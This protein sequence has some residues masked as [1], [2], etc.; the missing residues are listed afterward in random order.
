MRCG[1]F[2][3]FSFYVVLFG[4]EYSESVNQVK[5]KR[6][7]S[8]IIIFCVV[9]VM[10]SFFSLA[11]AE[12]KP[13]DASY[14]YEIASPTIVMVRSENL[15]NKS[16]GSGVC[17][18]N[19]ARIKTGS[20]GKKAGD[21]EITSSWILTNAH[22]V[23]DEKKTSISYGGKSYPAKVEY[24]DRVFDIAILYVEDVV[25]KIAEL[26]D[27]NIKIGSSV[28]AIGSPLGLNNSISDG[29]VSAIRQ[30]NSVPLI[31]TTAPISP[32]NSGG[33]LFDNNGNLVGITSFK[34]KE[35]EYLNFA[36]KSSFLYDLYE[37][38]V[39]AE[40]LLIRDQSRL[41]SS[42]DKYNLI[43]WL[44]IEKNSSGISL[45]KTILQAY[46][47]YA[48]NGND[49]ALDDDSLEKF[50]SDMAAKFRNSVATSDS[51]HNH[52]KLNSSSSSSQ[53]LML[54]CSFDFSTKNKYLSVEVDFKN[55]KANGH[56]ATITDDEIEFKGISINR[57]T[58]KA[59]FQ[60]GGYSSQGKCEPVTEKRF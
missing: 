58:G 25:V 57:Y 41:L 13:A 29:I 46:G 44:A 1:F 34:L 33:G 55:M 19:G 54:D 43:N 7:L 5:I 36:I 10:G 12:K 56:S 60:S 27:S 37:S 28:Y 35:G 4:V 30:K 42:N 18:K 14:V 53:T 51:E 15:I 26:S 40:L 24:L 22:V 31:Q 38:V 59:T 6:S 2:V 8:P 11:Y 21:Y 45:Y 32:G 3:L 23:I 50:Q 9:S 39:P 47:F 20:S 48:Q 16:Q 49:N 17:V 52:S